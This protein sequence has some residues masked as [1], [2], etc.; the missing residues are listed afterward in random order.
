MIM[1]FNALKKSFKYSLPVLFGY[2]PLGF[3]FGVMLAD[4]GYGPEWAF[5]M[6]IFI[7]IIQA[8]KCITSMRKMFIILFFMGEDI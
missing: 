8:D 6:S 7:F 4:K 2:I 1:M 5:F 3:A